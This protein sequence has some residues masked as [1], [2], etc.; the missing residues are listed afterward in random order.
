M[1]KNKKQNTIE[2]VNALFWRR[3]NESALE[4]LLVEELDRL[5]SLP[6]GAKEPEDPS[7]LAA[8]KRELAEELELSEEEYE[9][10]A[11]DIQVRFLYDKKGPLDTKKWESYPYSLSISTTAPIS[12]QVRI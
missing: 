12:S 4:I 1:K 5:W 3:K 11:T 9:L 7:L 6:G 2:Q 8:M 10:E